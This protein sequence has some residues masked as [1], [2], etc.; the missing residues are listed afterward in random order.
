MPQIVTGP[1][2]VVNQRLPLLHRAAA[3]ARRALRGPG[4]RLVYQSPLARP[5]RRALSSLAP[6]GPVIVTICG[7][8]LAGSNLWVDLSCE[9]YYWLGTHEERV[10]RLLA[11][12]VKP[13]FV[14][15]DIGAHV[16][17]F[18]LLFSRLVGTVGLV[19]AFEPLPE[20]FDRLTANIKANSLSNIEASPLA[21]SDEDGNATFVR[22]ASSFKGCLAQEE[23]A[24][25]K[26]LVRVQAARIDTIVSRGARPPDLLKIDVEGAE[27][28]V[29]R[30]SVRTIEAYRPWMLV[31]I[32]SPQA[33]RDVVDALPVP[34]HFLDVATGREAILP[35][36]RGHYFAWP[37]ETAC[38]EGI[39]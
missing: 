34:Y 32:H 25:A 23:P 6:T 24:D 17:F 5:L 30:G 9:K 15:Y 21:L 39:R 36:A 11:R 22:D 28:A 16:G 35:P 29:I 2:V 38:L 19:Y 4:T 1:E 37:R 31:E 18:T 20:N 7:G 27:A 26:S 3:E 13:G 33:G 14:V 8:E 12:R 10:Q